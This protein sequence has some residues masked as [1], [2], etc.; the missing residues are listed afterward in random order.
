MDVISL[1]SRS[2]VDN[3]AS[4]P[5]PPAL[6]QVARVELRQSGLSVLAPLAFL[7]SGRTVLDA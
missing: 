4:S 2:H 5:A 3:S 1:V 6:G 7:P